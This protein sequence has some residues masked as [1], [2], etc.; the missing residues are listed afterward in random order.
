MV[1]LV[2][3]ASAGIG[4]ATALRLQKNGLIVYAAARR[5]E[6]MQDL[7]EKGI[8]ALKMDVTDKQSVDTALSIIKKAHGGVDI[9]VNN[10]GVAEHGAVEDVSIDKAKAQFN[11]NLFG[12]AYL[13]D[14][15]LP[16]MR[17]NHHG[18][19]INVTSIA[20]RIYAPMTGWYFSSKYALEGLSKC[21]R[22]E[23][24]AFGIDVVIIQPGLISSEMTDITISNLLRNSGKGE[25]SAGAKFIGNFMNSYK[26][27]ESSP[28]VVARAVSRAVKSKH[29]KHRY[30]VGRFA[31]LSLLLFWL[32]P[33]RL[34]T[35]IYTIKFKSIM[36][37]GERSSTCN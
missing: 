13:I 3:G 16:H 6:K 32:V 29:P 11:V 20:G 15:C 17:K 25:Y 27:I 33:D 22:V 26:P 37:N 12:S 9:L 5:M 10:A 28:D 4:K 18:K 8:H 7:K 35:K 23:T 30:T 31:K 24:K 2:T 14:M 1:A 36:K 34:L 19:I 21:L